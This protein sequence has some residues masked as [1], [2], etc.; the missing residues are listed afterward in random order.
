VLNNGTMSIPAAIYSLVMFVTATVF[1]LWLI[2]R[3][4]AGAV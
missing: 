2:K 3:R 4:G 1:A